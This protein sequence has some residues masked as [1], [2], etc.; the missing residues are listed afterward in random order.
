MFNPLQGTTSA[1]DF[2]SSPLQQ[3]SPAALPQFSP[4]QARLDQAAQQI[5]RSLTNT[6]SGGI[7]QNQQMPQS[8]RGSAPY[9][10][11]QSMQGGYHDASGNISQNVNANKLYLYGGKFSDGTPVPPTPIPNQNAFGHAYKQGSLSSGIFWDH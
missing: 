5:L 6:I 8:A 3:P 11:S 4:E 9:V 1:A 2:A 10:W 7:N